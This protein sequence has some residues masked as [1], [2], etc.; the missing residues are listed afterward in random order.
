MTEGSIKLLLVDDHTIVRLGLTALFGTVA[1]FVVVGQ[2]DSAA[3]AVTE[4]RRC[5]PDVV[6]LDVRLP[7]GSGIEACREIRSEFP[8][9]RVIML[10]SYADD[11]AVIASILAGAAGY[12]LKQVAPERLVEAIETVAQGGSLLDPVATAVVLDRIRRSAAP[13]GQAAPTGLSEQEETILQLIADGK[14]NR[15]I[16]GHLC[17]S[18]H[19]VKTYVSKILQKLQLRRRAKAAAFIAR[20]SPQP[21]I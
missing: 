18:E 3:A 1:R 19:T 12:L 5:R 16:A 9:T 2:A 4:A 20:R 10:T 15:E 17:L 8:A 11:D 14:T 7:D 21:G 6:V 13:D